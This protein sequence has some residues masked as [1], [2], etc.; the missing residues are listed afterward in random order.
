YNSIFLRKRLKVNIK[1]ALDR[2]LIKKEFKFGMI[3]YLATFFI[4]MNYKVDQYFIKFM[5]GISELGVY[6]AAV[7]L[8]E[9]LFLIPASVASAIL[10][11]LYNISSDDM[12]ER[13]RITSST[14][15][16]TFYITFMLMIAGIFCTPLIPI[17]Y[18][19]Q[20]TG[21]IIPTIIL[22]IG[23][24]FASIGKISASYF[25]S[26]GQPKIHLLIAF[27]VFASN[28]ILNLLLIPVMGII[29]AALASTISYIFYGV[30]YIA[31][32]III[33]KFKFRDFFFINESDKENIRKIKIKIIK[34]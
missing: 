23:I 3:I 22:F 17:V 1:F 2:L 11:R 28:I 7:A 25:Q 30:L 6:T 20:Y 16:V 33:E 26:T 31:C 5:L 12:E 15:K 10:G 9:L 8:A 32:F 34:K 14:I 18:G 13:K 19:V 24:L 27:I 4:F 29:G 21:A